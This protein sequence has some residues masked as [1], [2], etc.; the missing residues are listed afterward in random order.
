M[1]KK[2]KGRSVSP[3]EYYFTLRRDLGFGPRLAAYTTVHRFSCSI[4]EWRA[5][6]ADMNVYFLSV[7]RKRSP[8]LGE[9]LLRAQIFQNEFNNRR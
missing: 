9:P 4:G 6:E 2:S 7:D 1:K 3:L 8:H 5:R